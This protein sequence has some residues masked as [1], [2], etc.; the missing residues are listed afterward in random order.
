MAASSPQAVAQA[1]AEA[2][3][4]GNTEAALELWLEDAVFVAADG[5]PRRG[6]AQI[7]DVFAAL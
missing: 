1:F 3:N 7:R 2:I 6:R 4:A 5:P